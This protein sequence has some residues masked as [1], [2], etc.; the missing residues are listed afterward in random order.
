MNIKITN[1]MLFNAVNA[2]DKKVEEIENYQDEL[3]EK[4][5]NH[6]DFT[7]CAISLLGA[8]LILA[9]FLGVFR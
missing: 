9:A 5:N 2:L 3:I 7:Q 1:K 4:H 8:L 6:V